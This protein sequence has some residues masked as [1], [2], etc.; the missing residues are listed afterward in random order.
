MPVG[1]GQELPDRDR[2]VE[3]MTRAWCL[4][5]AKASIMKAIPFPVVALMAL[6]LAACSNEAPQ[7]EPTETVDVALATPAV[8]DPTAPL[9]TAAPT[10]GASDGP[11]VREIPLALR[12]RWGLVPDDCTS[13][14]GDAKGLLAIAATDLRF[15]ESVGKM[16]TAT[17][18]DPARL[19]GTFAFTGEGMEW[20]RDISL[21]AS[22]DGRT[23]DYFDMGADSPPSRRTYT[24]CD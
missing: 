16:V 20:T 7:A 1:W 15:Y 18:V 5:R 2:V 14:R 21:Q 9:P 3:A 13:T 23:L 22:A 11:I 24:R 19:R 12:G 6:G 10:P 8:G 17:S 4:G